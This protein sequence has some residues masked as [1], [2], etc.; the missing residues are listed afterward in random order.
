[1]DCYC[2]F[3]NP[4]RHVFEDK[5]RKC[6]K[7]RRCCEC[8][9]MIERGEVYAFFSGVWDEGADSFSTCLKCNDLRSR[10]EFACAGFGEIA[11]QVS[12]S[13]AAD[14]EVLAF[15]ERRNRYL[16]E[17]HEKYREMTANMRSVVDAFNANT[18]KDLL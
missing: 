13:D 9:T 10:C 3:D 11:D 18:I 4:C 12:Q 1:M 14:V 17:T 8:G 5:K 7:P 6:R 15:M 2:E 16:T